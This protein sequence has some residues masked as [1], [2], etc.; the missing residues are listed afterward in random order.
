MWQ[1]Q[2]VPYSGCNMF[3]KVHNNI[4]VTKWDA[5]RDLVQ[6]Y[7]LKNLEKNHGGVLLLIKLQASTELFIVN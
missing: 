7:N 6:L 3:A 5:L 2:Y 1:G 4:P